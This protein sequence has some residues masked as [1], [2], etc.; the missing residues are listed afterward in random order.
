MISRRSLL[1]ST[2]LIALPSRLVYAQDYPSRLI[3]IVAA[4]SPGSATDML[5]RHL[6]AELGEVFNQATLVE[7]K[8]G[9]GGNIAIDHV[10][11]SPPGGYTL[12]VVY[13]MPYTNPWVAKTNYDPVKDFA[14]VARVVSSGLVMVTGTNSR[15]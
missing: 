8:V 13:S 11:K 12:L 4:A 7:N 3:R 15:F 9:A 2:L 10:A 1:A 5:A 6:A 14:P